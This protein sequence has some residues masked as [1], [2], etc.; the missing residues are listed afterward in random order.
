[1]RQRAISLDR[2]RQWES[3]HP[4]VLLPAAAVEAIGALYDLLPISARGRTVDAS[5]VMCL[6]QSLMR[7]SR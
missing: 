7:A 3:N 5:G 6:H 1:M 2:Y 4:A